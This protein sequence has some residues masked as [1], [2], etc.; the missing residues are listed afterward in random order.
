CAKIR[1]TFRSFF[2]LGSC[3]QT[4]KLLW[5]DCRSRFFYK[6]GT[7]ISSMCL[8]YSRT[9]NI[10]KQPGKTTFHFLSTMLQ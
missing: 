8:F 1:L 7:W 10:S 6:L 2:P 5:L 9:P 4:K 3:L